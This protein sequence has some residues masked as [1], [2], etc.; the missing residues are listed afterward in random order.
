[1]VVV[2][3][4]AINALPAAAEVASSATTLAL[5]ADREMD[6]KERPVAKVVKM[7]KDMKA[8]LEKEAADDEAVYEQIAC[9]CETNDKQKSKEIEDAQK[10]IAALEAAI[11]EYLA[12]MEE[13]KT[14]LASTK[15]AY[16]KNWDALNK[17]KALRMKEQQEFH[18]DETGMLD[19]IQACKQAIV[20][21][22]KHH[23]E[24]VQMKKVANGL[25]QLRPQLIS[26]SLTD[27][28]QKSLKT[29]L[30]HVDKA[31]EMSGSFLE[32]GHMGVPGF[33][34][35][36]PQSGQIFGI[37]KQLQEDFEKNLSQTQKDEMAAQEAFANLKSAKE[38]EMAAQ[39]KAIATMEADLADNMEKHA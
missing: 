18:D 38:D 4:L 26:D 39:K 3:L 37:L 17:A 1:M 11:A 33:Q 27:F 16:N 36:A 6:L 34:S 12:K 9:W 7:I 31:T 32:R 25:R 5:Q 28:Q 19:A 13:L 30:Q 14:K 29:F 8:Q 2:L 23:P 15:D 21:L 22:S 35:Y 20:V 10:K 24:L